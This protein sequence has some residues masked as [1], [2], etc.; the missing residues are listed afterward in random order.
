[1]LMLLK[2][3]IIG[4]ISGVASG[5]LGLTA[6]P[7]LVPL[8]VLF[9]VVNS[10]KTAIGTTLFAVLPPLSIGCLLYTSPSPRD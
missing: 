1:M 9:S 6:A 4:L 3:L 10:Y 8:L 2:I 5:A 7:S